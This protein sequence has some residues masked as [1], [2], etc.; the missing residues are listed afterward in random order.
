MNACSSLAESL[1][2]RL[3]NTTEQKPLHWSVFMKDFVENGQNSEAELVEAMNSLLLP[4]GTVAGRNHR[5]W[6]TLSQA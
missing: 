6:V 5:F 1:T 4:H 2:D 3:K